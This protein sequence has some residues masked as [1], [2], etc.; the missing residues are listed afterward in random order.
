MDKASIIKSLQLL[1]AGASKR[2]FVQ[3]VDCVLN[4]KDLDLKKPEGQ[5]DYY[6]QLPHS[7]GKK[8]TLCA[9]VGAELLVQAKS[10]CDKCI[11]DEEFKSFDKKAIKKLAVEYTFFIAQANL[12]NDVAKVF[13]RILGPRGKMPNPK[14]GA[15]VPANVNLQIT[16]DRLRNTVRVSNKQQASIK[17]TVGKENMTD[18]V[19]ADN[20]LSLYQTTA[21][22]LPNESQNV[23]EVLVKF[24]MSKPV[25]V[26]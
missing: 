8:V 23:R 9:L 5:V 21:S 20:I 18:D 3:S 24:S 16:T 19:L 14:A 15:V 6:F 26:Q 17:M 10:L 11:A 7:N 25:K 12:M 4:L 1:R 2:N 13:G 22:K